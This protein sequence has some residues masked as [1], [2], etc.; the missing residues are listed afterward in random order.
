MKKI[1]FLLIVSIC[2][3]SIL[4]AEPKREN[5]LS[6]HLVPKSAP[7]V[8][9]G[10]KNGFMISQSYNLKPPSERPIFDTP[11]QLIKYF[12]TQPQEIQE[13]GLWVVTTNPNAYSEDEMESTEILKKLCLEKDIILF[14]C[15]GMWL[16]N[17]WIRASQFHLEDSDD[18]Y[19]A[20]ESVEKGWQYFDKKDFNLALDNFN[21]A[22]LI[23]SH[24]APAYFGKAYVYSIQNNLDLAIENYKKAI[25]LEPNFAPAYSNL[26]LALMYSNKPEEALP[27]FKKALELEPRNGDAHVNIALYYFGMEDYKTSW[28]HIHKAQD[29]NAQIN[30]FFIKDLESKMKEPKK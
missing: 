29:L 18:I 1:I 21:Q 26:G 24:F 14:F 15:R 6:V 16:P 22:S 28:Y 13:N 19:R 12:L 8:F 2:I 5:G 23:Y 4:Y 20:K 9:G 7:G 3:N 27:M 30:P 10:N 17:G 11:E 25:D